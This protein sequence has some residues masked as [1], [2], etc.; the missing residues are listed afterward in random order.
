MAVKHFREL[1]VWKKAMDL[2]VGCYRHTDPFPSHE[3]FGLT[4][5][6]RRAAVSVSANIAE[7]QARFHT[8]EFLYHLSVASGS[9]AELETLLEISSRLGYLKQPQLE[10]LLA[11][12][13]EVGRMLQRLR[14]ALE[15]RQPNEPGRA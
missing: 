12:C 4:S 8:S 9:L 13:Q 7:G 15:R 14:Q 5:Q 11:G 6:I 10:R 3:Q 1:E 2:V